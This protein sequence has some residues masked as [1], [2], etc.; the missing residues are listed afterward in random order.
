MRSRA[1]SDQPLD[2][3]VVALLRSLVPTGAGPACS[4]PCSCV[5]G[6]CGHSAARFTARKVAVAACTGCDAHGAS[7]ACTSACMGSAE[8]G[9]ADPAGA[10]SAAGLT[11]AWSSSCAAAVARVPCSVAWAPSWIGVVDVLPGTV[12]CTLPSTVTSRA[13]GVRACKVARA[14]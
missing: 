3:L 12:V 4:V 13:M 5:A 10:A 7:V 9:F 2:G 14:L 6:A 8:A 1:S 11:R